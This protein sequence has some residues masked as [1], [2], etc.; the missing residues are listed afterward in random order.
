MALLLTLV[1][2]NLDMQVPLGTVKIQISWL[3]K[4]PSDMDLHCLSLS[5]WICINNLDIVIRLIEQLEVGVTSLFSIKK[6][7]RVVNPRNYH[8]IVLT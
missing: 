3:L 5:M 6:V 4:K 2:P 8:E 1:L 7:T